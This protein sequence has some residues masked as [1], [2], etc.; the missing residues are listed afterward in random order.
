MVSAKSS[1]AN[2]EKITAVILQS[3]K[4]AFNDATNVT[5]SKVEDLYKAV[6][7]LDGQTLSVWYNPEGNLIALSRK[8]NPVQLSLSLQ[9]SLKRRSEGYTLTDLFE[10]DNDEGISYYAAL[11]NNSKKIVL[12]STS[13]GEDWSIYKKNKK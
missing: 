1:Y 13:S 10:I 11:E 5:W 2:E 8:M 12:K 9:K 4:T 3:F 7:V 6:F